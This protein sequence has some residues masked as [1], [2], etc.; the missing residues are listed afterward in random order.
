MEWYVLQGVCALCLVCHAMGSGFP[1]GLSPCLLCW[2]TGLKLCIWGH[3]T[4][5]LT[6]WEHCH[7]GTPSTPELGTPWGSLAWLCLPSCLPL[8]LAP[9][10]ALCTPFPAQAGGSFWVGF[11]G[12]AEGEAP[13]QGPSGGGSRGLIGS[14]LGEFLWRVGHP[15]PEPQGARSAFLL[16]SY[17]CLL[18]PQ[19]WGVSLLVLDEDNLGRKECAFPEGGARCQFL[20]WWLWN[21]G[22]VNE[23]LLSLQNSSCSR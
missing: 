8:C 9:H 18:P 14:I 13:A 21:T 22:F 12:N 19:P 1:C 4:L 10:P 23:H 3:T 6:F 2:V 7:P 11:A 16:H 15:L 20:P 17:A 5:A